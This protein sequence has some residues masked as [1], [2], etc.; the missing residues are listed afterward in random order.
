MA[1]DILLRLSRS[2]AWLALLLIPIGYHF[3][4]ADGG[5][6]DQLT[7]AA[8]IATIGTLIAYC[9]FEAWW[10]RLLAGI[11]FATAGLV[12]QQFGSDA[13]ASAFNQC[14]E[15]A[16]SV[17]QALA[18]FRQSRGHFPA[19]LT[20]LAMDLPCKPRFG[21]TLLRYAKTPAG[22]HLSFGTFVTH[23]ASESEAFSG[24]K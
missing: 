11:L 15:Q 23:S 12:A 9:L 16:E 3:G 13:H 24:H 21:S 18:D 2:L 22:Y 6:D 7:R 5:I 19:A 17:R 10:L 1:P 8:G 14:I 20:D 4:V